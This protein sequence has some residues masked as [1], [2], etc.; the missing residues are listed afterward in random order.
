MANDAPG[1]IMYGYLGKIFGFSDLTL[2]AAAG[3][4]Q[5]NA[6]TSNATWRNL[7]NFGDDPRDQSRIKKGIEIYKS[8]H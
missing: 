4:A 7:Q 5:I 8:R 1:N 2:L 6:G 3:F